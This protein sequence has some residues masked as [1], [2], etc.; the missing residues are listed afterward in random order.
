MKIKKILSGLV[1]GA[2]AM[3]TLAGVSSFSASADSNPE[4]PIIPALNGLVKCQLRKSAEG[5]GKDVRFL[6]V[7]KESDVLYG[8]SAEW[9]IEAAT[10][11]A[12]DDFQEVEIQELTDKAYKS[13]IANGVKVNANDV[14]KEIWNWSADTEYCF[15]LSQP[16]GSFDDGDKVLGSIWVL[17]FSTSLDR[18]VTIGATTSSSKPDS[19]SEVEESSSEVE[20]SSSEAEESSSTAEPSGEEVIW[21]GSEDLG[22]WKNDVELGVAGIP[23]AK[24]NGI[25]TIEYEATGAAQIQVINKLGEDFTWTPMETA[26]GAEY[27]DTTGGKL[28][29]KLTAAQ[30]EALAASKAI[31]LKGTGAVVTKMIYTAPGGNAGQTEVIWEGEE[32][33]NAWKTDV[34]LGVAGIPT[35]EENGILTIEYT[36]TGAAQIQVINKLG[37][38]WT[39][40]PMQT[41]D[42]AEYFDTTGGK[43]QIKLTAQQAA[44]L[45]AGKEMHVKGTGAVITKI[46]YT[47]PGGNAG[48]TEVI[49]TGEEDLGA[50][51]NDVELGVAGIPMAEENGI[52]TIKYTSTGDAQI[53]VINK[54]GDAWT[55]TPMETADGEEY[56]DTTGGELQIKLTAAQAAA[57][58]SSKAM[59][60]KGQNAVVTEITYTTPGSKPSDS[61]SE[62]E[63]SSAVVEDSSTVVEDSSS[64]SEQ[65]STEEVLWEGEEDLGAWKND[66]ELGVAGIPTAVENGILTI[67]YTATGAA[68]I[69]VIN[70]I[71]AD[72]TWTPMETAEGA[73]YF[74]TTGGKL[75]IKLTAAQAAALAESKS[76]F[77]KGTGA[78]V[79][80]MTYTAPGGDAGK[81]EVIWEGEEDLNAWK[82]DVNLG[83]AGIPLAEEGGIL[84]IEYTGTGAAQIQV[85]NKLGANW[86]WTPMQTADGAEYFDTTGGKLQ[87]KLTAAQAADL[88]A[89]KEMHI[90][91]TGA[92][93]TKITYTTPGGNAGVTET[94]WEG[95]EDLN[96][97]KADV[98]LGVAGI[99]MAE[100]GGILT[101]EYT[102]TGAAQI[103]IINKLGADWTWTPMLTAE[104]DD[105]FDTTGGKLQI[106]LTAQ[107]AEEL[108]AGK[109]MHVKG[110]GAVITKL[111][112]TSK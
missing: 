45:A 25:L 57:L 77:L 62:A 42:G 13:V 97:W 84:A 95:E 12:P 68:Q 3:S 66:V 8:A 88:A 30:A 109:E 27:F 94:I 96:A 23:N 78:V 69:Q 4:T 50:W 1:A 108:A 101:V 33:L 34:N 17:N 22:A 48:Q 91:G 31:F 87:I 16:V 14:A 71:G 107:Q 39:W 81:T 59:Y 5:T 35:A 61:S 32:D 67:E 104:G 60:L 49:W 103:Q 73:E 54:L 98:N 74:D 24:E 90:K 89:G 64:T 76:I 9:T 93:I 110:T 47:T 86:T 38:D 55:W 51:K 75:Q 83:V 28:Q 18:E 102:G 46:T 79:T 44:E 7:V 37:A 56:F 36:A 99:P 85:I 70:K 43:L 19:S 6:A 29:I 111:T 11:D 72:W 10:A 53:Q 58:A 106:K 41:A 82:T 63:D 20:E 26:D 105:F 40:T 100:E 80:K 2:L 112:Y 52:L 15:I 65:P 21:E 92:V